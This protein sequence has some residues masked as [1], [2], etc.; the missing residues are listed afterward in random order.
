MVDQRVGEG[1]PGRPGADDQ[2]VGVQH[3]RHLPM[4]TPRRTE[5]S[6]G[7]DSEGLGRHTDLF[8]EMDS[9]DEVL[10]VGIAVMP[11]GL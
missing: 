10:M 11:R 2:V 3:P 4:L 8:G 9:G 5:E 6:T 1:H 7:A